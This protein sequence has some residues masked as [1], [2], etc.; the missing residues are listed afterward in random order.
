MT[1]TPGWNGGANEESWQTTGSAYEFVYVTFELPANY[2]TGDLTLN[3]WWVTNAAG[4]ADFYIMAELQSVMTLSQG[5]W[6]WW[7][8]GGAFVAIDDIGAQHDVH[9]TTLTQGVSSGKLGSDYAG[10]VFHGIV[11]GWDVTA[12]DIGIMGLE[13]EY[14]GYV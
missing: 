10:Q 13:I 9:R 1:G 3:V 6:Y 4:A 7:Y 2:A 8:G 12:E 11:G 5:A 14:T